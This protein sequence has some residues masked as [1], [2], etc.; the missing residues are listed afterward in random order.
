M[1]SQELPWV[2]FKLKDQLFAISSQ[3]VAA[4]NKKIEVTLLPNLPSH[5]KGIINYRN[6]I[7]KIYDT[8]NIF[9]IKTRQEENSEFGLMMDS[10]K[11]D[12]I[13]WLDELENSVAENRVFSLTTDPHACAFGKWYYGF[14]TNNLRLRK[15]LDRFEN[16]HNRIHSIAQKIEVFKE[17]NDF[18]SAQK[19]IDETKSNELSLMINLFNEITDAI[20]LHS[21]EHVILL[22]N[23][24]KR[25]ALE[26]D[27]VLA[28]EHLEPADTKEAKEILSGKGSL[29]V[30]IQLG[31]RT[32]EEYVIML[33]D[34]DFLQ[35]II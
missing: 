10:R 2:V 27:D 12:H 33:S 25:C 30:N 15:F 22:K 3:N 11:R 19:L 18:K 32:N 29:P 7:F 28:I 34:T 35:S 20:R 4:I 9:S 21:N 6:E 23:N 17:N 24:D 16:P 26:V 31:K 14:Q 5:I 13:K 8:R 1:D